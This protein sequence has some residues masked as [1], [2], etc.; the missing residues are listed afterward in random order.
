[1]LE[2]DN[3]SK[4]PLLQFQ[5]IICRHISLRAHLHTY[6]NMGRKEVEK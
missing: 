4:F 1:M 3:N 6:I 5:T 2:N